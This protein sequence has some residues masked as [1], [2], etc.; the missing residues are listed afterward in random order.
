MAKR[1]TDRGTNANRRISPGEVGY[2]RRNQQTHEDPVLTLARAFRLNAKRVQIA[3]AAIA[4]AISTL[5][6]EH[7][8]RMPASTTLAMNRPEATGDAAYAL[9]N[10]FSAAE[11][12]RALKSAGRESEIPDNVL[13]FARI[14]EEYRAA[15]SAAGLDALDQTFASSVTVFRGIRRKLLMT[16]ARTVA[17]V[18]AKLK[19]LPFTQDHGAI[20]ESVTRDL[21]QLAKA[22]KRA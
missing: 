22:T 10:C 7:P 15:R 13:H 9:V 12:R 14:E 1:N 2:S 4:R 21:M 17:G 11:I 20:L 6:P 5:P 3:E 19:L 16:R 8:A 18:L